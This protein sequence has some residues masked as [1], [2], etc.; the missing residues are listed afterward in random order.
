MYRFTLAACFLIGSFVAAADPWKVPVGSEYEQEIA[1][2]VADILPKWHYSQ[3]KFDD[4]KSSHAFDKFLK[5]LDPYRRYFLASD[6]EQLSTHRYTIDDE[7]RVGDIDF[8]SE[9][10]E[11]FVTRVR[12]RVDKIE[13][14]LEQPFDFM[15]DE[16]YDSDRED[17]PWCVTTDE[18][19]EV[20]RRRLKN[21]MLY[22]IIVAEENAKRAA[23]RAAAKAAKDAE[24]AET[25]AESIPD[26]GS[27]VVVAGDGAADVIVEPVAEGTGEEPPVEVEAEVE[28]V[29]R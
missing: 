15:V 9:V 19:D 18:L 26:P 17:A 10:F 27:T 5:R 22:R 28:A 23:K 12:A 16:N 7:L 24:A 2:L 29:L 4:D 14:L 6:I 11:L 3:E 20:W 8:S 21:A 1:K 25:A 13:I